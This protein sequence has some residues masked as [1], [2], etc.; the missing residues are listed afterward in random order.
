[1]LSVDIFGYDIPEIK[2]MADANKIRFKKPVQPTF[3]KKQ[4]S[5]DNPAEKMNN[6]TPKNLKAVSKISGGANMLDVKLAVGNM[7][8]QMRL[9]IG[10][11]VIIV[12][13]GVY[14]KTAIN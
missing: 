13:V 8:G 6:S 4:A 1:M 14:T 12:C 11:V 3:N 5:A 10:D 9:G 7:V 2:R